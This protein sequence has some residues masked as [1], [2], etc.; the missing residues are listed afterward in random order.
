MLTFLGSV[1][2]HTLGLGW[3]GGVMLTFLGSVTWHTLGL[4][5][6]GWGDVNVP[7]KRYV[8]YAGVGVGGVKH[9]LLEFSRTVRTRAGDVVKAGTQVLDRQ[10]RSLKDYLPKTLATKSKAGHVNQS[11]W[12]WTYSWQY[13]YNNGKD[14]WTAV[15]HVLKH[16]RNAWVQN[17]PRLYGRRY[18]VY[19]R[20]PTENSF[21]SSATTRRDA[22]DIASTSTK[23]RWIATSC[24]AG[25]MLGRCKS[26]MHQGD[27]HGYHPNNSN[28]YVYFL[29]L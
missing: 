23:S 16:I 22:R 27:D 29:Y 20:L 10:W 21:P 2:W 18:L 13:R 4:G 24:S 25:K 8:T 12:Q 14:L 26:W 7:W 19:G 17:S 3:G 11:L 9:A 1:T 28:T 15:P 5:W 6:G